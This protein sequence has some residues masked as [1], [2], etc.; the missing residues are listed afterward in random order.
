M[1]P[2]NF[3]RWVHILVSRGSMYSSCASSTCILASLVRARVAKMSRISSAR[4]ITRLPIASSM[5]LPCVGDSSSSNRT[6][7][8][9]VSLDALAQLVDLA[10][11]EVRAGM[12]A[13]DLLRELADDGRACGVREL[14]QLAQM[15]VDETPRARTLERGAHEQRPLCRRRDDDRISAYG[16]ILFRVSVIAR[17]PSS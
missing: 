2:R 11:A 13:V 7:D 16:I 5:F 15:V 12:R 8:A 9:S 17:R 1:P 14:R 6:S 10:L 3:S 4:S